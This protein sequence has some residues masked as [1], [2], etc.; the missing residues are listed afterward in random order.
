MSV[1]MFHRHLSATKL[2][3]EQQ[4]DQRQV[5]STIVHINILKN[6]V[7]LYELIYMNL[8]TILKLIIMSHYYDT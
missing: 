6:N 8:F 4:L 5:I 7:F 2:S 3:I 1:D